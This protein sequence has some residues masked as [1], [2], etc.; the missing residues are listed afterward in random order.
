MY[1]VRGSPRHEFQVI[2]LVFRQKKLE[3]KHTLLL[4]L[5]RRRVHSFATG[6]F[7]RERILVIV[8]ATANT[9]K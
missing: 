7:S 6:M 5:C 8:D 2:F 4:H 9:G 1:G 3:I